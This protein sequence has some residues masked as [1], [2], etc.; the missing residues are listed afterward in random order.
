MGTK[1]GHVG[2]TGGPCTRHHGRSQAGRWQSK[3]R[4]VLLNRGW[5]T[6][7]LRRQIV[8]VTSEPSIHL[9]TGWFCFVT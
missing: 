5:I 8:G 4:A 7:V 6:R 1:R 2:A 9:S 3:P